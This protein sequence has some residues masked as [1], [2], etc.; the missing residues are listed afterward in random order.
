MDAD[1]LWNGLAA[2][3]FPLAIVAVIATTYLL[4]RPPRR[5]RAALLYAPEARCTRDAERHWQVVLD[6]MTRRR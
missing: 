4:T 2:F 1:E 5:K 3:G 6:H